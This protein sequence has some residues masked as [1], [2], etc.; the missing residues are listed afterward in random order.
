MSRRIIIDD[1]IAKPDLV[2]T[3]DTSLDLQDWLLI[4]GAA[5][6]EAA[7]LAIWWPSALI[8]A[9]VFCLGFAYLIERDKKHKP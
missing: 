6:A 4:G 2:V 3:V 9:A 8:V 7:A 1:E 5:A